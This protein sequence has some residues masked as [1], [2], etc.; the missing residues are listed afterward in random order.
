[1][2]KKK[3]QILIAYHPGSCITYNLRKGY[4]EKKSQPGEKPETN[5]FRNEDDA[6]LI[7]RMKMEGYPMVLGHAGTREVF[8]G[9]PLLRPFQNSHDP[10]AVH[11]K[12]VDYT[13]RQLSGRFGPIPRVFVLY[14]PTATDAA[15]FVFTLD[16]HMQ[17]YEKNLASKK[18]LL[19]L[20]K[21]VSLTS[22]AFKIRTL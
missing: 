18:N 21:E 8:N 2:E 11:M 5:N 3:N 16:S 14:F 17:E 20:K 15:S 4:R 13:K 12:L 6:P 7:V 1:M 19:L 22:P 10:T 9:T